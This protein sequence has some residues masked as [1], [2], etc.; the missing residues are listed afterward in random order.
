MIAIDKI[1][2]PRHLQGKDIVAIRPLRN[3]FLRY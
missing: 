3:L 2:N 1:D